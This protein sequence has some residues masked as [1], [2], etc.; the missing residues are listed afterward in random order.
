VL[1]LKERIA[2]LQLAQASDNPT[3]KSRPPA[4]PV[5]KAAKPSPAPLPRRPT[6]KIAPAN[7]IP[8]PVC[9][10]PNECGPQRNSIAPPPPPERR[11]APPALPPRRQS[12]PS[13]LEAPPALP[14]RR[15]SE[16]SVTRRQSND[17]LSSVM[18]G[19]SSISA[20]SSR[21]GLSA[22]SEGNQAGGQRFRVKAPEYDP[23]KLPALPE[24]RV[25]P[26]PSLPTRREA[27]A[28]HQRNE[29]APQPSAQSASQ[30]GFNSQAAPPPIPSN[31]P[32]PAIA[33][34]NPHSPAAPPTPGPLIVEL[35]ASTFDDIILRSGKPAFVDF[36]AP[37]CKCKS[38]QSPKL[39][40]RNTHALQTAKSW[41]LCTKN[42][43]KSTSTRTLQL[44]R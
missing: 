39:L 28:L 10:S 4:P 34:A 13:A 1:T 37:F 2:A 30:H 21:T 35:N 44:P 14:P 3:P 6:N 41:I 31:H 32:Q 18:S 27:P 5:L 11:K 38:H 33:P 7:G 16:L 43:R 23:A 26:P 12:Q 42:L 17:S 40:A 20:I 25:Q 24:R 36:Y 9:K 19:R 29:W 15:P 22:T 8:Q